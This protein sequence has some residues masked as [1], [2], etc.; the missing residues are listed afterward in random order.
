MKGKVVRC[1]H[2]FVSLFL[3]INNHETTIEIYSNRIEHIDIPV[4][5]NEGLGH[6]AANNRILIAGKSEPNRGPHQ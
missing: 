2:P 6:D 1:C 4:K 5:D 3:K